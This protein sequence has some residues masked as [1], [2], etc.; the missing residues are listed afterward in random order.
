ML[1]LSSSSSRRPHHIPRHAKTTR[2]T[3][4]S[5]LS[6]SRK[7]TLPTTHIRDHSQLMSVGYF[8]FERQYESS[9]T[10]HKPKV[11]SRQ[12][13]A[14]GH[15]PPAVSHCHQLPVTSCAL[16]AG[17]SVHI[18]YLRMPRRREEQ[19]LRSCRDQTRARGSRHCL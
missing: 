16:A 1:S 11:T 10:N 14:E 19:R 12:A 2:R 18:I 7:L 15:Q 8:D 6:S 3:K 9:A 17:S 13:Q 4:T 5:V